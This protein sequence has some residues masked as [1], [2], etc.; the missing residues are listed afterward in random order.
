MFN[1]KWLDIKPHPGGLIKISAVVDGSIEE[2]AKSASEAASKPYEL[3]LKPVSKKRSLTA[4]GYYQVLLDKLTA[5]VGG[6]R[7]E[8]HRELLARYGVTDLGHDGKPIL[9]RMQADI[10]PAE[11]SG[12]YV[13]A[14]GEQDGYIVYRV[15][16]G[17]S[18]MDSVE[19]SHLLDGLISECK[20]LGIEVLSDEELQRLYKVQES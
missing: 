16:K 2:A 4:N 5:V 7:E 18:K 17:S 19:F 1:V 9:L 11:L 12:I 3:I 14:I 6:R 20:E 10:D 15:L 13:D 8:I